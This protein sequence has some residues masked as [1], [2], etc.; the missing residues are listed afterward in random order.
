MKDALHSF[1]E[2]TAFSREANEFLVKF[3]SVKSNQFLLIIPAFKST[4]DLSFFIEGVEYLYK[5]ELYPSF[6]ISSFFLDNLLLQD[7]IKKCKLLA[8]KYKV[9]VDLIQNDDTSCKTSIKEVF[10]S[11]TY[12]KIMVCSG[13][14]KNIKGDIVNRLYLNNQTVELNKDSQNI[15]AWAQPLLSKL[16]SEHTLQFNTS[17]DILPELF[18]NHGAGSMLSLGYHFLNLTATQVDL[19]KIVGLIELGFN[20]ELSSKYLS[21]IKSHHFCIEENYRG[22]I[23]ISK[24]NDFFYLDKIVV[25]PSY[26]GRGLGSLLLDQLMEQ[27]NQLSHNNPKLV[28]RAKK[29]N[30]F[31]AKYTALLRLLASQFPDKCMTVNGAAYVYHF[32]GLT[33]SQIEPALQFMQNRPSSFN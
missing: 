31:L 28:W 25:N 27:V 26:L 33:H 19:N 4:E 29:D 3:H 13:P 23:I 32:I 11:H 22:G 9:E 14:I 5:L 21:E 6:Y 18:T 2:K 30:P 12:Y 1:F 15:I 24:Q 8:K 20:K 16:G 17:K 10:N 7:T